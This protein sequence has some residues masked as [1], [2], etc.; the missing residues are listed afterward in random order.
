MQSLPRVM[1]VRS[2]RST[3]AIQLPVLASSMSVA[4]TTRFTLLRMLLY[5]R[6]TDRSHISTTWHSLLARTH[7]MPLRPI[8]PSPTTRA[9]FQ[10]VPLISLAIWLLSVVEGV[11]LLLRLR[12]CMTMVHRRC[13][14][15]TPMEDRCSIRTA[16]KIG[17]ASC[18][19]RVYATV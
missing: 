10:Q 15:S 9:R 2:E 8:R 18:R 7:F 19:E 3:Q 5:P 12:I 1:K 13:S 14:S 4:P 11:H 6:G 17:R 16:L